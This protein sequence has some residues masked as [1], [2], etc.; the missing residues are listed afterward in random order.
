LIILNKDKSI[1]ALFK[2]V[3]STANENDMFSG[4]TRL[5]QIFPNPFSSETTIPFELKDA[6]HIKIS[7]FNILRQEVSTLINE[8]LSPGKY[9]I[10]WDGRD[11]NGNRVTDGIYFC[12]MES[13]NQL[14]QVGKIVFRRL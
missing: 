2:Q 11:K 1:T 3:I 13:D 6:S 10:Q 12:Q 9:A 7:V 8:H 4:Q 5:G 14:V